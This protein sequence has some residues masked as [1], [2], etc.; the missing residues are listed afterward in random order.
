MADTEQPLT[1]LLV[2][3]LTEVI[4]REVRRRLDKRRGLFIT[5]APGFERWVSRDEIETIW[6]IRMREEQ[7]LTSE[8][9]RNV[10]HV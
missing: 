1:P 10:L 5:I 8:E 4:E 7:P 3:E 9:E 2:A 6:R